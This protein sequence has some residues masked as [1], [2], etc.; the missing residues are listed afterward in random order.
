MQLIY[1]GQ[2]PN[3]I[4]IYICCKIKKKKKLDTKEFFCGNNK[5]WKISEGYNLINGAQL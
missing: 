5:K 1:F 4:T 2:K 3:E